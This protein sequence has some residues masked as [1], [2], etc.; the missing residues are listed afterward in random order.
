MMKIK[1]NQSCPVCG[2]KLSLLK[3]KNKF[4]CENCRSKLKSNT[5]V[6]ALVPLLI[7]SF[8]AGPISN[9]LFDNIFY[10]YACDFFIVIASALVFWPL[11]LEVSKING[12]RY[13]LK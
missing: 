2:Q 1:K 12:V 5:V 11:F 10:R 4:E 3:I 9:Y 7:G 6:A 8:L 13:E